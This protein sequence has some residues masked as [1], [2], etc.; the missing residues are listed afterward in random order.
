ME[1][2]LKTLLRAAADKRP[3]NRRQLR[4]AIRR[5]GF[6]A[7]W[8][9]DGELIEDW[10]AMVTKGVARVRL[11]ARGMSVLRTLDPTRK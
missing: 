5:R 6:V 9:P 10:T 7:M 1:E 8:A 3:L 2:E 11:T 4:L